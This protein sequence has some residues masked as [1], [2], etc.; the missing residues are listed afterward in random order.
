[1]SQASNTSEFSATGAAVEDEVITRVIKDRRRTG[2]AREYLCRIQGVT[3]PAWRASNDV[4]GECLAT[5]EV[6]EAARVDLEE[7]ERTKDSRKQ[8]RDAEKASL[9]SVFRSTR[10]GK[11]LLSQKINATE[12]GCCPEPYVRPE[13]RVPT[14]GRPSPP[15]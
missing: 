4:S 8:K 7:Y 5:W 10:W 14:F 13:P 3:D 12:G 15:P 9:T 6:G 1:M 2:G 11:M